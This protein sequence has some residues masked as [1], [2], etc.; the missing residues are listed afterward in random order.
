MK[1]LVKRKILYIS[2]SRA[3]YG[4]V[5]NLLIKL[6]SLYYFDVNIIVI[7]DHLDKSKGFTI[8]E[9][10]NDK[11]NILKKI[12]INKNFYLKASDKL[13]FFQNNLSNALKKY[14]PD[15]VILLGDR[16]EILAS[17][18][19]C[20]FLNLKILHISGGE[21]T[22]GSSDDLFRHLISK[23]SD[24]HFVSEKDYKKRLLQLGEN[25]KNIYVIGSLP[26][27]NILKLKLLEKDNLE[28]K[29]NFKFRK[30]NI[31]ITFHPDTSVAEYHAND[32][33]ILLSALSK[34]KQVLKIF[35]FPNADK[36]SNLII[37]KINNFCKKN[38]NSIVIKSF[39]Q[40]DYF[41][42]L[43][44]VSFLIGNSSSGITEAPIFNKIS[45][46]L[47]NRQK[48]RLISSTVINCR[49]S[50]SEITNKIKKILNHNLRLK[51]NKI[52]F[53]KKNAST[54]ALKYIKEIINKNKNIKIF[55]DL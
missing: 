30:K 41:S 43:K 18:L 28:K 32:F 13:F 34:Y 6:N 14:S 53:N 2:S 55:E 29:Y 7:G 27:D 3:D 36:G 12:P 40:V 54:N 26:T 51:K 49:I 37:N 23:L 44:N 21:K 11:I 10:Y 52:Y 22:L 46:N 17:A 50:K 33:E 16:K 5:R 45:I 38:D 9:I 25:K 15:L 20:F 8:N 4:I 35:T 39:G 19:A 1:K 47:G 24:F 31:L 48:G 42:V